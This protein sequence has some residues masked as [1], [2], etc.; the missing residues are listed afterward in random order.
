MRKRRGIVLSG[1]LAL[2]VVLNGCGGLETAPEGGEAAEGQENVLGENGNASGEKEMSE[3]KEEEGEDSAS[4]GESLTVTEGIQKAMD[5]ADS[6]T[7]GEY[8]LLPDGSVVTR[9]ETLDNFAGDYAASPDVKKIADSSSQTEL[10]VL[11][12]GGDLYFHQTKI[13]SGI[14][15]VVYST[16]N[17]NQTAV[18]ISDDT[19]YYVTV[20]DPADVSARLRETKPETYF[21]VG[22]K[23]IHYFESN[24]SFSDLSE[25]DM[26][27]AEG[28]YASLGAE[29]RDFFLLNDTG[30]VYMDNSDGV[31]TEYV[32][33]EFLDWDNMALID[34]AKYR[35]GGD[36]LD[37][38]WEL[39]VAG[40]QGDGT[41]KACGFYA[42]EILSW[43][44]LNDI[45]M[46]DG[47]I[48]GLTPEGTLKVTGTLAQYVQEDLAAWTNLVGVKVGNHTG[49]VVVNAVDAD[50]TF[51]HLQ[52]DD[53]KSENLVVI[54]SAEGG[55]KDETSWWYRYSPDG[56]VSRSGGGNGWEVQ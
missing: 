18:C 3:E 36:A 44:N 46:D 28:T 13:L 23:T 48:V 17:V 45:V 21:D 2:A 40:I 29:K 41:V 39:T 25:E 52:Y 31:S 43:G 19:I 47:L 1:V 26:A 53:T 10:L 32:G 37:P 56:T 51:Y 20:R 14:K 27:L 16:T 38:E 12:E 34:A 42:D 6:L 35:V 50:G 54:M 4:G 11:T 33:M 24:Y 7:T 5:A 8:F 22:D 30:Q 55:C 9:G 15:D 49:T